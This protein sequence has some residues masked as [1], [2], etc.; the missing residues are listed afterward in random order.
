MFKTKA[1]TFMESVIMGEAVLNDIHDFIDEWHD[2]ADD[3]RTLPQFLGL[4]DVQYAAWV[5][6]PRCLASLV[7]SRRFKKS[8]KLR[9]FPTLGRQLVSERE[10]IQRRLKEIGEAPGIAIGISSAS[11]PGKR[12]MS[13]AA[14]ARITAAQ[15]KRWAAA[16]G[17]TTKDAAKP[18]KRQLSPAARR[19]IA[20]AARKRW[21]AAKKAGKNN[22]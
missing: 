22:L 13:A 17:A 1:K 19:K 10:S 6:N 3:K 11:G 8:D 4:T 9:K 15:R 18:A 20:E 16:R 14:R 2:S 7:R 21:A 5:E 12:Q